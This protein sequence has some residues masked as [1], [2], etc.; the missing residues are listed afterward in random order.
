M[1]PEPY[2]EYDTIILGAGVT[3]LAI[4][5]ATGVPIFE[6]Q[7]FPGGIST[8]YYL[9]ERERER[10][11]HRSGDEE[12]FRFEYGG[13]HWL[14]GAD[15]ETLR[16]IDS[17][18]PMNEYHR[19]A[20]VYF[21]KENKFYPYPIQTHP[22][23]HST[24]FSEQ[25]DQRREASSESNPS[26]MEAWY[27]TQFGERLMQI[28]FQPFQEKYT[29]GLWNLIAPQDEYKSP[30]IQTSSEEQR[31]KGEHGY[32]VRYSYPRNGLDHLMHA[33]ADQAKIHYG[34]NIVRIDS[35]KKIAF[36]EDGFSI[37]YKRIASTLPLHRMVEIAGIELKQSADPYTSVLTLNIGAIRGARCPDSH[38]LYIPDCDT[39]FYR[40][41]FYSNVDPSFLPKS[42][43]SSQDCVSLYVEKAFRGGYT[44]DETDARR[45]GDAVIRQLQQ[46]GFIGEVLA[47]DATWIDVA[48]TWKYPGSRW[49]DEALEALRACE[50]YQVGRYARWKFQGIVESIREGRT[51]AEEYLRSSPGT[52]DEA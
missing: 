7:D 27:R 49:S 24:S 28:F 22:D 44:I 26:T 4:A 20:S 23:F 3:G 5:H 31:A 2:H 12:D 33:L 36:I 40:V 50:I 13:G 11:A 51:F 37:R 39:G 9:R 17:I 30:T 14:F 19:S 25:Q 34:K 15:K 18:S 35:K 29:V 1:S 48:Y 32:N 45:Y 41:G 10:L 16:W 38:W 6:K 46:W 43:R 21:S 52:T 8:S 47:L 42:R